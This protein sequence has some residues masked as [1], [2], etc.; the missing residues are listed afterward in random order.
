MKEGGERCSK[1]TE[2]SDYNCMPFLHNHAWFISVASLARPWAFVLGQCVLLLVGLMPLF[3]LICLPANHIRRL[4]WPRRIASRTLFT[5]TRIVGPAHQWGSEGA[6]LL[7]GD[8]DDE[9][10]AAN[11]LR[12]R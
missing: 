8:A 11:T 10:E 12:R 1:E 3:P 4:L 7:L 2:G 9:V 5:R 6:H